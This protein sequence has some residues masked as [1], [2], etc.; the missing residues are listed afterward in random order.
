MLVAGASGLFE[1]R[2]CGRSR[3]YDMKPLFLLSH[4]SN[5]APVGQLW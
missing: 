5:F 3:Y 2:K 4:H 1:G